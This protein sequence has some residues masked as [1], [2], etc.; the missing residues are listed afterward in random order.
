VAT[1]IVAGFIGLLNVA[2][3]TAVFGQTRIDPAR[4]VT[5]VTAGGVSGSPGPP[6]P[7]FLSGSPQETIT[8]ANKNAG[9]KILNNLKFRIS[10]FP[11]PSFIEWSGRTL[12]LLDL[13][14]LNVA[15]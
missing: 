8:T 3:I 2:V 6:I 10:F 11:S 14:I 12:F 13:R 1:L 7:A 4:G 15:R 9:N 5:A